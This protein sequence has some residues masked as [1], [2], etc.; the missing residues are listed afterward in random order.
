[1]ASPDVLSVS[2]LSTPITVRLRRQQVPQGVRV[3]VECECGVVATYDVT[4]GVGLGATAVVKVCILW[5]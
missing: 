4:C 5:K 3:P 2:N 1:L